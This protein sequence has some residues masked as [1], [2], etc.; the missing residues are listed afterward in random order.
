MGEQ[1]YRPS[2][3]TAAKT[4]HEIAF[5]WCRREDLNVGGGEPSRSEASAHGFRSFVGITGG[6]D[7][8]DFDEFLIDVSRE[9][10]A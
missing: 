4:R 7:R 10:L 6:G 8:I 1:Q 5:V 9:L 3:P 2:R